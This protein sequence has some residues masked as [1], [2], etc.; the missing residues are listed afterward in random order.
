MLGVTVRMSGIL[1]LITVLILAG[2]VT[3]LIRIRKR[4]EFKVNVVLVAIVGFLTLT[5]I[6]MGQFTL[7][8]MGA[9]FFLTILV[10]LVIALLVRKILKV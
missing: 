1:D 4:E 3:F 5:L 8:L 7:R 10:S 6:S 2:L 9:I